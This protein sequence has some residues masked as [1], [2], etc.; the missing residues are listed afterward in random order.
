M[1]RIIAAGKKQQAY[2]YTLL[3]GEPFLYEGLWDIFARHPDCYFQVITNGMFFTAE[4]V[5]RL[6]A[7]PAT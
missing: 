5:A 4:N 2:F 3:G 7:A 6:Q 1:D